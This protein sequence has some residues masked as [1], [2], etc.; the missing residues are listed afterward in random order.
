MHS[1][2]DY[3]QQLQNI[4]QTGLVVM[5]DVSRFSAYHTEIVCPHMALMIVERGSTRV[6]YDMQEKTQRQYDIACL[7]PGHLLNP[8]ESSDDFKASIVVL[9]HQLYKNLQFHVFSHDYNKFNFAPISPL[10]PEQA[11]NMLTVIHQLEI[12]AG[13][14]EE[15]LPHRYKMLLSLLAVGYEYLN[16]YRRRQD[17]QW[18]DNR[19]VDLLNRFCDLVVDHY[20]ESREVKYYAALLNLTPKYFSKVIASLTGG[21]SPAD[22]INQY[23]ASQAKHIISTQH[24]SVKETAYRLGFSESA[25]FCRFFKRITGLTPQEYKNKKQEIL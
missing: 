16:L 18:A 9:S 12:V 19:H 14:T 22:W 13:H 25:S 10:T 23:V 2:T 21:Q 4:E 7:L 17:L 3:A 15:E 8:M 20:R 24:L 5:R 11:E 1:T 6:L